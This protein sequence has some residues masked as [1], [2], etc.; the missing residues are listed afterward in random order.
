MAGPLKR[1]PRKLLHYNVDF[2]RATFLLDDKTW[3]NLKSLLP[4]TIRA[5]VVDTF[6]HSDIEGACKWLEIRHRNVQR[7]AAY[8]AI[9]RSPGKGQL[10]PF[11]KLVEQLHLAKL[12]ANKIRETGALYK[13]Q[14]DELTVFEKLSTMCDEADRILAELTAKEEPSDVGPAWPIF[15]RA[16]GQ[17]L[18]E[19]G[20]FP[21]S[22]SGSVYDGTNPTWFQK[23]MLT[24]NAALPEQ[25]QHRS[26]S[27]NAFAASVTKAMQGDRKTG[28]TRA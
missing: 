5:G 27:P 19:W 18:K 6:L 22:A 21:P 17:A 28:K 4:K 10:A 8:A 20:G 9:M 7:G 1:S 12:A 13:V 2:G 15:V 23:F 3:N 25:L 11:E 24:L 16:I 14:F 26:N